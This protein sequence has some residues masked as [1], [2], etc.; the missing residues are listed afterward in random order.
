MGVVQG[1]AGVG[2]VVSL[3]VSGGSGRTQHI[4]AGVRAG[5]RVTMAMD[6]TYM[7]A[8]DALA[9]FET[10]VSQDN[11]IIQTSGDL[12]GHTIGLVLMRPT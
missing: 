8:G 1:D 2:A 10:F 11:Q 9:S 7:P 6:V 12:K 3:S 4:A 5:D